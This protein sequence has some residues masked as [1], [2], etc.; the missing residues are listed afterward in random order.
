MN[1]RFFLGQTKASQ[2]RQKAPRAN[3]QVI[4]QITDSTS[5][6]FIRALP[7]S[8]RR[9]KLFKGATAEAVSVIPL[10]I[11]TVSVNGDLSSAVLDAIPHH[12]KNIDIYG[13]QIEILGNHTDL[14]SRSG[15]TVTINT[16]KV[17]MTRKL[18]KKEAAAALLL[19]R[20]NSE[21]RPLPSQQPKHTFTFGSASGAKD[22]QKINDRVRSAA[23][24]AP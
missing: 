11:K 4:P 14:L 3:G 18:T 13:R 22:I 10:H 9:I 23:T 5:P 20:R 16:M 17:S 6:E 21:N 2:V 12:V 19:M 24:K 1:K 15:V 7:S 8:V